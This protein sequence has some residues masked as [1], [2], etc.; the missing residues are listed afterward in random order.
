M[1][2]RQR[3]TISIPRGLL[4]L[5]FVL[6]LLGCAD[7]VADDRVR[8]GEML[9]DPEALTAWLERKSPD[10]RAAVARLG[11]SRSELA[12]SRLLPNP[13]LSLGLADVTVGETNPLGLGL[14]ETAI[15]SATVSETVELGKRGPRIASA[16]LRL[17]SGHETY[18]DAVAGRIAE[19]RQALGRVAYLGSRQAALQESRV[20]SHRILELQQTRFEHGDLSGNDLDRLRTDTEL[21]EAEIEQNGSEYGATLAVCRA[22]LTAECDPAGAELSSLDGAAEVPE[23]PPSP[24][25]TGLARPDIRALQLLGRSAKEDAT[26]A[27]RRAIPDPSLSVGYTRDRLVI[28]GDQPRSLAFGLS[29]SLPVFDHGQHDAARAELRAV[30]LE[31]TA[32]AAL[33]R[34]RSDVT[35]LLERR[36]TLE[37]TLRQLRQGALPR[38]KRVLDS[39]VAAFNQGELSMT[40]LLLARRTHTDLVLKVMELAYGA[41]S[42]RNELRQ[43]L[44]L[45]ADLVRQREGD[46]WARR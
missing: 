21:L 10:L 28:S 14:A 20:D 33:S 1:I 36:A 5:P 16:R 17:D 9:A 3:H 19:A 11:Q 44:G 26:L 37:R 32:A 43:A 29:L 35:A 4:A 7:A 39:T 24:G 25:V 38:S 31:Q 6:T 41:F 40:D 45:D 2:L 18:L 46:S 27:R 12:Q 15:W 22:V 30:E 23:A 8:V 13:S 34:A 42:A